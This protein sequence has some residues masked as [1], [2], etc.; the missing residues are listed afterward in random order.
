MQRF[1]GAAPHPGTL[2]V[3]ANEV[4]V[5]EEASEAY[6]VFAAATAEFEDDRRVIVEKVI[7]ATSPGAERLVGVDDVRGFDSCG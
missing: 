3:D 1:G 5:R 6:G 4:L 7:V 2:D